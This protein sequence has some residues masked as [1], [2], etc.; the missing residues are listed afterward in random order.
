MNIPIYQV[1][2]FTDKAFGGNPAAVCPL[3]AWI[4]EGLMQAI[5]AENNLAETA[6]FVPSNGG[7]KIRWFTPTA[8][9]D[10]CGHAT[11][12]SASVIFEKLAHSGD[13]VSFESRSGPLRV[14]RRSDG[15]LAL[16]FPS[17]PGAPCSPPQGFVEALGAV[18]VE[19]L[20][21]VKYMAVFASEDEV[22]A[23]APNMDKVAR[24]DAEGVIVT[25]A[26]TDVDFVSRFFAPKLGIPEDPVTGSA[27]CTLIPYW[28]QRLGKTVLRA[29]QVS[30]RGGELW[31]ELLADGVIIAGRAADYMEGTIR[32]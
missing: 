5:A 8:E 21:A 26:G 24:F 13:K 2:A 29:R 7:F 30:R 28:A 4:D 25:S 10:L 31:C 27:H 15:L 12:A 1:D 22:R 18:P 3:E 14:T 6:F 32:L 19:I 20:K 9:V 23:I 16:E 11:L 17:L